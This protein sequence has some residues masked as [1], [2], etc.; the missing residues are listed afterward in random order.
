MKFWKWRLE[1]KLKRIANEEKI[2]FLVR[3]LWEEMDSAYDLT[4]VAGKFKSLE[5]DMFRDGELN[6]GFL[7]KSYTRCI[8]IK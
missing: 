6:I 2:D 4:V 8:K 7:G 1:L 5:L 3:E